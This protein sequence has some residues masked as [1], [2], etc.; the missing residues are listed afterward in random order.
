MIVYI[1]T[2]FSL[3]ISSRRRHTSWTSDWSSDVCS[4]D[5]GSPN[6]ARVDGLVPFLDNWINLSFFRIAGSFW[7]SRSNFTP[8]RKSH[9]L[10]DGRVC[11]IGR[12]SCRERAYRLKTKDYIT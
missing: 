11:Q 5:L 9:V 6:T 4:S 8:P 12:A 7:M 2:Y 1:L 3:F 10:A